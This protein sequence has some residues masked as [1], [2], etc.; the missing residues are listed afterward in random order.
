MA[1]DAFR[2][3]RDHH[4]PPVLWIR[5]AHDQLLFFQAV[6]HRCD[7]RC[8]HAQLPADLPGSHLHV[9]ISVQTEQPH[10]SHLTAQRGA[11]LIFLESVRIFIHHPNQLL[12]QCSIV[13]VSY[14][15]F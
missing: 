11:D 15:S 9:L 5:P 1:G 12:C 10:D 3:Q 2:R 8:G 7:A 6:E 13:H 14:A 4:A